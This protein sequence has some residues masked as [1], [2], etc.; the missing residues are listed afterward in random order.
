MPRLY[1]P[2]PIARNILRKGN[3]GR[4]RNGILYLKGG[5]YAA[6]IEELGIQP[7]KIYPLSDIFKGK[8]ETDKSI[9]YFPAERLVL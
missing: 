4:L 5:D 8:I 2:I 7:S 1:T 9:V 3:S 6:E